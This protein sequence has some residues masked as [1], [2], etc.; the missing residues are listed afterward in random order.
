MAYFSTMVCTQLHIHMCMCVGRREGGRGGGSGPASCTDLGGGGGGVGTPLKKLIASYCRLAL[1]IIMS[2][3]LLCPKSG[4]GIAICSCTQAQT[5][6]S[7]GSPA[8]AVQK[9]AV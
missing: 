7:Q 1:T 6:P 8:V 4:C 2:L 9:Q 5:L 3:N